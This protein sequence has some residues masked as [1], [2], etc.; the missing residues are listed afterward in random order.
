MLRCLASGTLTL[1]TLWLLIVLLLHQLIFLESFLNHLS[2]VLLSLLLVLNCLFF[3]YLCFLFPSVFSCLGPWILS[4][5]WHP[6]TVWYLY[7]WL[8]LFFLII[9]WNLLIDLFSSLLVWLLLLLLL[10]CSGL[11]GFWL[12]R[13][14]SSVNHLPAWSWAT[15]R[16]WFFF[17]KFVYF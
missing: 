9:N 13:I 14:A 1:I 11:L 12:W 10:R 6:P 5:I 7:G 16:F 4:L 8:I 17:R 2:I 15:L 3:G